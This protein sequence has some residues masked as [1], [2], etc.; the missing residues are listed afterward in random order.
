MAKLLNKAETLYQEEKTRFHQEILQFH[1]NKGTPFKNTPTIDGKDVDLYLLYWL[2]TAKGGW[3]KVNR[4]SAWDELLECFEIPD[5]TVNGAILLKQ[6][7]LRYLDTYE[8]IHYLGEDG[9]DGDD[10]G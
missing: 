1:R 4:K 7:Y 10:D 6:T 8:K 9:D 2:V 5:S 3:E